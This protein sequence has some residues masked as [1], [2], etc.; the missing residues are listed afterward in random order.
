MQIGPWQILLIVLIVI[1]VFGAHKLPSIAKQMGKSIRTFRQEV[2]K[3]E[4]K[5][6]ER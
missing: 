5:K 3:D 4:K 2:E 1:L 6:N